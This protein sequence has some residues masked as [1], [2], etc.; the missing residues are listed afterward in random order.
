[1]LL[2]YFPA[3]YN[4]SGSPVYS[5]FL[6]TVVGFAAAWWLIWFEEAT[7]RTLE[8]YLR[9]TSNSAHPA[10]EERSHVCLIS[11]QLCSLMLR[12]DKPQT[13]Y[14]VEVRERNLN[15]L[16]KWIIYKYFYV[17][18]YKIFRVCWGRPMQSTKRPLLVFN[19]MR[20][21]WSCHL[22]QYRVPPRTWLLSF[23]LF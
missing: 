18:K 14:D 17:H 8:R 22:Q 7:P 5:Y 23:R 2:P 10:R 1:M 11:P 19:I 9:G 12:S 15:Y 13:M 6:H 3:F 16:R 20:F 21:R 4:P